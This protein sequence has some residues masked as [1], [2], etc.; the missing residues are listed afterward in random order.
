MKTSKANFQFKF[1]CIT[2]AATQRY[3]GTRA[4]QDRLKNIIIDCADLLAAFAT[5]R[6]RVWLRRSRWWSD[7]AE[8]LET[9]IPV[10][11]IRKEREGQDDD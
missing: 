3:C 11:E 10:S 6:S 4:G 7:F 1:K 8:S 9:G 2:S 5:W